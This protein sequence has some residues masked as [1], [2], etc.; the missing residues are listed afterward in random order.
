MTSEEALKAAM[1]TWPSGMRPVVHWSESQGGKIAHA[2]SVR[3]APA[4]AADKPAFRGPNLFACSEPHRIR[5]AVV[6]DAYLPARRVATLT[7]L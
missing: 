1:S 2:H 6:Q 5:T 3:L 4:P 7:Y